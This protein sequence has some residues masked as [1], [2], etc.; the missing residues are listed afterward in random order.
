MAYWYK[1][2]PW[3]TQGNTDIPNDGVSFQEE[4][5]DPNSLWNYYKNMI[6]IR[7]DNPVIDYGAYKNIS[8]NNDKVFS[9]ERYF[10]SKKVVVAVNLSAEQQDVIISSEG[11]LKNIF[12][13]IKSETGSGD[14]KISLP[15]YGVA[16]WSNN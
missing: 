6:A 3:F 4:Q 16:V 9:F 5:N 10:G 14:A 1:N 13:D 11:T 12:G 2:G 7:K 8:N 15:A